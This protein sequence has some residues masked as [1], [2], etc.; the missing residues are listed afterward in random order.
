MSHLLAGLGVQLDV[1]DER[2]ALGALDGATFTGVLTPSQAEA[3]EAMLAHDLG[4]LCAP[5]GIGKTV[6]ATSLIAT[7]GR[8]TLVLVS[9]QPLAEQWAKRLVEFLDL[10]LAQIGTIGA[11]RQKLTGSLDIATRRRAS[12]AATTYP[13]CSASTAMSSST[14]ATTSPPSRLSRSCRP[15]PRAT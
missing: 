5:P 2:T 8:S 7:R 15:R 12:R 10:D 11:G 14:N 3:A 4:V 1:S 13:A 6:I 9:R